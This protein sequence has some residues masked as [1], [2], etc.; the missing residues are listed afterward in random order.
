MTPA[1][2]S[3]QAFPYTTAR[4]DRLWA[5][6]GLWPCRMSYV[7]ELGWEL[8]TSPPSSPWGSSR[9]SW[10]P[11]QGWWTSSWSGSTPWTRSVWR[12]GY[13]HWGSDI[14]PDDT[15]LEAGLGFAVKLGKSDFLGREALLR[16]KEEGLNRRLAV[17][18]LD[19]PAPLIYHDEPI[20]RNGEIVSANTHGAYGHMLG[21]SL[22]MGWL[23]KEGIDD[24]WIL[25]GKYEIDV[26]GELVP[27]KV[28]LSPPHDPKG[29]RLKG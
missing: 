24:D 9:P 3:N 22:G 21:R 25:A 27:A 19:D 5:L 16:Q 8:Y 13:K 4:S 6:P 7:G 14:G 20:Y 11:G 1:D 18:T 12:K 17:F 23:E 26:E 28:H 29:E 15:P 2:L 10:R